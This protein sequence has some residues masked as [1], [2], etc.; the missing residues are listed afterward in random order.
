[1]EEGQRFG[2][3]CGGNCGERENWGGGGEGIGIEGFNIKTRCLHWIQKCE[4]SQGRHFV[5]W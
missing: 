5:D 3:G 1:M 2:A 4:K